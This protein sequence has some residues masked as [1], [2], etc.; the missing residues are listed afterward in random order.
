MEKQGSDIEETLQDA[1]YKNKCVSF[2]IKNWFMLATIVGV[3]V[4]F[5]IAF[6]VRSV[7]PDSVT[8]TWLTMPGDIYLRVLT[9]TILPLIASNILV[10]IATLEPKKNGKISIIGMALVICSNFV[11]SL[12]G[13]ACAAI[14]RPG[15]SFSIYVASSSVT[16]ALSKVLSFFLRSL[17]SAFIS[18]LIFGHRL[19]FCFE[20]TRTAQYRRIGSRIL[21]G[22][23][24]SNAPLV[25]SGLSPSDIFKDMFYNFF[26]D[27]IVGVTIYQYRTEIVNYTTNEKVGNST[28]S[29]TNMIGRY[30]DKYLLFTYMFDFTG[31][32]F[33]ALAFGAAANAVGTVAK[34]FVNFFEALA[35][36]VTKLMS[37]FLLFTP[38]GVCFMVVGSLLDRQNI[39]SDFVQLGLFIATV[40]TGLLI[41]FIIVIIVLWIASRKNPL[42]LL[43]YSLE[44]FLISF[45][46]TSP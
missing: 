32:L 33:C 22:D 3:G 46:T 23:S 30:I 26:P 36:T 39:A 27:N 31:V 34:P 15:E 43:K 13:T 25:G 21:T 37:V 20:A 28:R 9:L 40:I 24:G 29:G 45:A 16:Q 44:P 41:Y 17:A 42:R 12:I 1:K 19:C 10:V 4:G 2:L 7:Q 6:G 35:A 14:I 8:I 11:G 5:G 38:I 18:I